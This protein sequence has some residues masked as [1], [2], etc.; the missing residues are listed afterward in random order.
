MANFTP[1]AGFIERVSALVNGPKYETPVIPVYEPIHTTV[2]MNDVLLDN[3]VV[4]ALKAPGVEIE[5]PRVKRAVGMIGK[6]YPKK[7]TWFA[8]Q[9]TASW[10]L[11][12]DSNCIV[13]GSTMDVNAAIVYAVL[14][15][16]EA[17]KTGT[18]LGKGVMVC[19]INAKT[20]VVSYTFP[21]LPSIDKF[22]GNDVLEITKVDTGIY[23]HPVS[24]PVITEGI[25]HPMRLMMVTNSV[26]FVPKAV[27]PFR[28]R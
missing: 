5:D 8:H 12:T 20:G 28:L 24:Q 1:T 23:I 25:E 15:T 4:S 14:E 21:D 16:T 10:A 6:C 22:I 7:G 13:I 2:E 26:L 18:G 9:V 3:A 19:N 27:L 11:C 17:M